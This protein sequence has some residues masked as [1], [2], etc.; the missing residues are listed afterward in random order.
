MTVV[1][2]VI[3][4]DDAFLVTRRL[5]GSHLA[6]YWEFP[7]GKCE[8]HESLESCLR[9]ELVEE[10][11]VEIRVGHEL[12]TNLFS[13]DDRDVEL[14]FYRCELLGEPEPLLG[15]EMRWVGR[16]D[17]RSL[18]LPPADAALVEL[19]TSPAARR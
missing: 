12:L 16:G 9:R 18:D 2:A 8:P 17:L 4:R 7:G 15:Q 5:E 19:L 11:R 3:E 14:H 13:Y 1:A 6:G 10:L